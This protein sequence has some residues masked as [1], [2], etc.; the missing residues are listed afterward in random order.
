[1]PEGGRLRYGEGVLVGYRWYES[2][3]IDVS[4]PFG[5]GL[6]YTSFEIGAP[7]LSTPTIEPGRSI[8][9]RIPVTNTGSRPGSEIVQLYVA[10]T[11]PGV[12]RP[13]KELKGFAKVLPRS[14]RVDRPRDRAR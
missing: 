9:V 5:H 4:F 11:D 7:V 8:S 12:F 6:S 14:W 3:D 13:P 10:P 1:M 2:R